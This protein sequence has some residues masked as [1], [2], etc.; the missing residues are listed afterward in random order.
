MV[1]DPQTGEYI[2]I[3]TAGRE[4]F[5]R[6][7]KQFIALVNPAYPLLWRAILLQQIVGDTRFKYLEVD[8]TLTEEEA[9]QLNDQEDHSITRVI[10]VPDDGEYEIIVRKK[11]NL[12]EDNTEDQP[13]DKPQQE[14]IAT[15]HMMSMYHIFNTVQPVEPT[16]IISEE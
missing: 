12:P 8:P 11:E 6:L 7:I 3:R 15:A 14:L 16:E 2:N 4:Q 1:L 13:V 5:E 9:D 10:S